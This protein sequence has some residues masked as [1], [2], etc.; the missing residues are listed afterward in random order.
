[1]ILIHDMVQILDVISFVVWNKLEE[2]P[3]FTVSDL[4]RQ[5]KD[6]LIPFQSLISILFF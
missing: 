5:R 3:V 1:M 6:L 4:V 2:Y